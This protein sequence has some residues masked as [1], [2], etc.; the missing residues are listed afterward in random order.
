ML[1]RSGGYDIDAGRDFL[2]VGAG[3]VL[4]GLTRRNL[5]DAR[6]LEPEALLSS[7]DLESSSVA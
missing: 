6:V 2:G 1:F 3:S 7:E 5:P 4:A